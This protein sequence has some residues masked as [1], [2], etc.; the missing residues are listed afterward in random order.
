MEL[1]N[2]RTLVRIAELGSFSAAEEDL[3]YT[4]STV[5]MQIKALEEEL[6]APLFDRIGRRVRLTDSGRQ[7]VQSARVM[8]AESERLLRSVQSEENALV[9]VGVYESLCGGFLPGTIRRFSESQPGAVLSVVTAPRTELERRLQ[10]DQ[11][12][13]IWVYGHDAPEHTRMLAE[14]SHPTQPLCARW[15]A[16]C[17][18][19]DRP[20]R[21]AGAEDHLHRTGLPLPEAAGTLSGG[22]G[23]VA[24][25]IP[26][27]G[28]RRC[29]AAVCGGRTG[30]RL[31]AGVHFPGKA[32]GS[33]GGGF[34]DRRLRAPAVQPD[35]CPFGQVADT[36]DGGLCPG[37]TDRGGT[38]ITRLPRA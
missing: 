11:V 35:L 3:G 4:Q 31:H 13:L 36:G 28:Q 26:G 8:L 27:N 37:G 2:L 34:W 20:G 22:A 18:T 7:A 29:G 17:R 21:A 6:G 1:R 10:A 5:T 19:A 9:R 15:F 38:G 25:S 14:F 23:A 24:R 16:P 33:C 32:G 30:N 12:D